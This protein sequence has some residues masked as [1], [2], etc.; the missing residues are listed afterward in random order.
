MHLKPH[1]TFPLYFS[2][3]IQNGHSLSEKQKRRLPK[4]QF[5]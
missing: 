1:V 5:Y 4:N 2:F 3:H